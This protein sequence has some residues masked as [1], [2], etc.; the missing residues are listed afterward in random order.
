M[1]PDLVNLTGDRLLHPSTTLTKFT[2]AADNPLKYVDP[3]GQ[4]V[5]IYYEAGN[6]YPGHTML[7]AYNQET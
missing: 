4:D 2:Y 7:L 1:A 6:P 5:T 3:D